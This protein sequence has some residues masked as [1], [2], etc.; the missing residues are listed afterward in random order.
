MAVFIPDIFSGYLNG[1]RQAN[2]DNWNDLTKYNDV[3]NGQLDNAFKMATFDPAVRTAWNQG[4][5]SDNATIRDTLATDSAQ[6]TYGVYSNN[7]GPEMLGLYNAQTLANNNALL[8]YQFRQST[9]NADLS[10]LYMPTFYQQQA[11]QGQMSLEQLRNG[12]QVAGDLSVQPGAGVGATNTGTTDNT[13]ASAREQVNNV[14]NGNFSF[15]SPSNLGLD[16]NLGIGALGNTF[17]ASG[18]P[19]P[20][21]KPQTPNE[22]MGVSALFTRS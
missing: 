5:Q 20:Q 14:A 6:R 18:R 17:D 22:A 15:G 7:Y 3:Q 11:E 21:F 4:T 13:T 2:T 10:Y 19:T 8:P 1:M 16:P 12:G 9:Q